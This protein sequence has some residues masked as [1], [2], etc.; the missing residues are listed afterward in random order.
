MVKV[1]VTE[2]DEKAKRIALTMRLNDTALPRENNGNTSTGAASRQKVPENTRQM[3]SLASAPSS[4]ALAAA[5]AKLKAC[6]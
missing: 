2:I 6:A 5:F 4:G 3:A 1:K